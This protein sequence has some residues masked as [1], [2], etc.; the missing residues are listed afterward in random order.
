VVNEEKVTPIWYQLFYEMVDEF[1]EES[2]FLWNNREL[3]DFC[4]G[5][6]EDAIMVTGAGI[7]KGRDAILRAY[8]EAYPDTSRMGTI[9]VEGINICLP[10]NDKDE[11][12]DV[13]VS[14]AT[15]IVRCVITL[16]GNIIED[17]Y[18]MLTFVLDDKGEIFIAQDTSNS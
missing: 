7:Y 17:G 14:M 3:E 4:K 9:S 18:S 10:P 6:T 1:N 5:Y 8:Q 16:N 11:E 2:V 13:L 12:H 15:A